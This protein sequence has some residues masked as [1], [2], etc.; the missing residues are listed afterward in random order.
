MHGVL[1]AEGYVQWG[2]NFHHVHTRYMFDLSFHIDRLKPSHCL[3][4]A[5]RKPY[6]E[7]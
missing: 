2:L 3:D 1:E 7:R 5:C 4:T 6:D